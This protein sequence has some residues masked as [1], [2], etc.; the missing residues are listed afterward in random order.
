MSY[1]ADIRV[2]HRIHLNDSKRV[3]DS[4]MKYRESKA[5]P[6]SLG[7]LVYIIKANV[8]AYRLTQGPS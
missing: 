3:L 8:Y 7:K 6:A 5:G 2:Y 4:G 1:F